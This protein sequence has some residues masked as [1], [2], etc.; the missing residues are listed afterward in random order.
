MKPIRILLWAV[1]AVVLVTVLALLAVIL[2]V[3]PNAYRSNIADLVRAKTGRELRIDGNLKLSFFPWIAVDVGRATVGNAAGFGEQSMLEIEHA[4]IGVRLIPLLSKKLDVRRVEIDGLKLRLTVTADGHN[5]WSDLGKQAGSPPQSPPTGGS[6]PAAPSGF[7]GQ[8]A[9]V[10][11]RH[12]M[13]VYQNLA[14]NSVWTLSNVNLETGELQAD[15]PMSLK[16]DGAFDNGPQ[17]PSGTLTVAT[18]VLPAGDSKAL[19]FKNLSVAMQLKTSPQA[20]TAWSLGFSAPQ[21]A[22]DIGAQTLKLDAVDIHLGD[23]IVHGSLSGEKIVDSPTFS[24]HLQSTLQP[25]RSVLEKLNISLPVTRD[26]KAFDSLAFAVDLK[27][28]STSVALQNLVAT[29]D[30]SHLKGRVAIADLKSSA[31]R[32]DLDLDRIDVDRYRSP[33]ASVTAASSAKSEDFPVKPLRALN[34][35]GDVRVGQATVAGVVL[36]NLRLGVNAAAGAVRLS[37]VQADLS[38]GHF[39]SDV[40][41]DAKTA[42]LGLALDGKLTDINFKPLLKNLLDSERLLGRGTADLHFTG[43]GANIDALLDSLKGKASLMVKDGALAGVDVWYELRRAQSLLKATAAP[44]GKSENQTRFD[45]LQFSADVDH[46]VA[47]TH[48]LIASTPFMKI[49]GAGTVGVKAPHAL[50]MQV[51]ALVNKL[52]ASGAGAAGGAAGDLVAAKI[53]V[54]IT[55]TAADPKVRPDIENMA[56]ERVKLEIDKKKDELQNQLQDKLKDLFKR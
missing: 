37:P 10:S 44:E 18:D 24:G 36:A 52:P 8:I 30:Q 42:A 46:G 32:F 56:K 12:A 16:L 31:L 50:D 53:P 28:T 27:T 51:T 17:G 38:G 22:L 20:K 54:R 2:L 7:R 49:T 26:A 29:F 5:N 14:S 35:Q 47:T 33:A 45:Q 25:L 40:R 48:D 9:G 4:R 6:P 41:L 3:D 34:A 15:R 21:V 23:A 55:G 13:I 19:G 1:G 43:R 11:L 39:S